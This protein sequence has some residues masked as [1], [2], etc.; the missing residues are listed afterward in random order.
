M[1]I[2]AG[3]ICFVTGGASGLGEA[4]VRMLHSQGASVAIADM[5]EERLDM[6]KTELKERILC[7]KCDVTKESDVQ[8]AIEQTVSHFGG[9]LHVALACAGVAWPSMMLTSKK[10]LDTKSFEM[11]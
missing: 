7:L 11:V 5:N 8:T 3:M 10:S 6:L 2:K 1:K 9:A 4:T